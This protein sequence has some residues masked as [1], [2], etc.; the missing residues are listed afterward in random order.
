MTQVRCI[1]HLYPHNILFHSRERLGGVRNGLRGLRGEARTSEK[2]L[3]KKPE[4]ELLF[5]RY[6]DQDALPSSELLLHIW[7]EN[8]SS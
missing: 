2:D 6:Y 8:L 1:E 5:L 4:L 3:D 7:Y